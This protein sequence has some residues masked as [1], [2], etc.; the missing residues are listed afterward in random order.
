MMRRLTLG[1]VVVAIAVLLAAGLV[2]RTL[3][4]R[5]QQRAE[6]AVPAQPPQSVELAPGERIE[7][8]KTL[9][10]KKITTRRFYPGTHRVELL[11]NGRAVAETTFQLR[12][13][14]DSPG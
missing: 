5:A 6:A 7:R 10:F 13:G 3:H 11:V 2:V 9:S 12:A 4:V 1:W 14:G 8:K